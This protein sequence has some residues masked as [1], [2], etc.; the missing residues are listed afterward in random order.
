MSPSDRVQAR[1]T[2]KHRVR[3]RVHFLPTPHIPHFKKPF[4]EQ[5][6]SRLDLH[7]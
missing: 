5:V 7:R 3:R 4:R 1:L 2:A 6:L